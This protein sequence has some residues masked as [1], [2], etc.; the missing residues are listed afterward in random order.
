MA[1]IN[2]QVIEEVRVSANIVDVVGSYV[3]LRKRGK[4]YVGL[5]PFHAEKTPSFT[6]NDDKQIFHCFGCGASGSVFDFLMRTRN[7]TFS[8]A[9]E[10]LAKRVGMTLPAGRETEHGKRVRELADR[11]SRANQLAADY[12]HNALIKGGAA[13][14]ARQY[15]QR[16]GIGREVIRNFQLGYAPQSWESLK[17]YLLGKKVSLEVA[18]QAGLLAKK[19]QGDAYDRFR[20]RLIFPIR[21]M[22]GRTVGFGGRALDESLPKYLNSPDSPIF[23]KG[24]ILYG[25]DTARESCRQQGQVLA[26]EGYFDLLALYSHGIHQVVAPLGT[27]LSGHH[28]RLMN[29]LAPEAVIVFDGDEAG[30]KAAMRS[31][32]LFLKEKLPVRMLTLPADMDPDD[33]LRQHGETDFLSRLRKAKPLLEVFLDR[34]FQGY[35]G[36]ASAKLQVIRSVRSVLGL[37]DSAVTREA[38]LRMLTQRLDVSEEALKEELGWDRGSRVGTASRLTQVG[39]TGVPT[40]EEVVLRVLVHYPQWISELMDAEVTESFQGEPLR[41]V[42]RLLVKYAAGTGNLDLGRLLVDVQDEKLRKVLSGWSVE[43]SPWPEQIARLRLREYLEGIKSRKKRGEEELKRLQKEIEA[44]E[45]SEDEQLLAELLT[46]K[47]SL[48]AKRSNVAPNLSKGEMV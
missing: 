9:V 40:M 24:R 27:A 22:R 18:I 2:R 32:E 37:L 35:D 41:Q 31:L 21:D 48:L 7:L 47:A 10:E 28:I 36:S 15:L 11:L 34:S 14:I 4:N 23:H 19:S 25:L 33:F 12:F 1:R 46:R 26:V 20:H 6:V 16:R 38:Y 5:C 39:D 44:A 45:Q 17:R 29:R 8:E 3:S 43:E 13:E 30:M 42:A